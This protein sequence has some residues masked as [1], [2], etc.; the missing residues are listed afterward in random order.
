MVGQK[1]RKHGRQFALFVAYFRAAT[2]KL[3]DSRCNVLFL[4]IIYLL[5]LLF[6]FLAFLH[7]N[8][9]LCGCVNMVVVVCAR[10]EGFFVLI[11]YGTSFTSLSVYCLFLLTILNHKT[12]QQKMA[13]THRYQLHEAFIC[14]VWRLDVIY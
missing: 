2:F 4:I 10:Q 11:N 1:I 12:M 8:V 3:I 6:F 5:L 14:L 13:E 7:V 9:C